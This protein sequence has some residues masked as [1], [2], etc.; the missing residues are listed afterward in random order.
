MGRK[1]VRMSGD[2]SAAAR[3]AKVLAFDCVG[4]RHIRLDDTFAL[5]KSAATPFVHTFTLLLAERPGA[6]TWETQLTGMPPIA[7]TWASIFCGVGTA[8]IHMDGVPANVGMLL[9]GD[10]PRGESISISAL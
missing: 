9:S 10:N 1:G 4:A 8:Y 3:I 7:L 6:F 2:Y 5:E